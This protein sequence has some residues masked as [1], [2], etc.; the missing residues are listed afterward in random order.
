MALSDQGDVLLDVQVRNERIVQGD[1]PPSGM[2]FQERIPVLLQDILLIEESQ[3]IDR[4]INV[5]TSINMMA[6][7]TRIMP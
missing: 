7:K 5:S 4:A 2:I 1:D 3:M 6:R